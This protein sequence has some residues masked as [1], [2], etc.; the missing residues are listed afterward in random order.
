MLPESVRQG[1]FC[2]SFVTILPKW[3]Q[4]ILI[5][6]LSYPCMQVNMGNMVAASFSPLKKKARNLASHISTR[7][8]VSDD[9]PRTRGRRQE[10]SAK[11]T[12]SKSWLSL[13]Q[14]LHTFASF[15]GN[16]TLELYSKQRVHTCMK[17]WTVAHKGTN[18][19]PNFLHKACLVTEFTSFSYSHA[20]WYL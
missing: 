18:F 17:F 4:N 8:S 14:V 5:I 20:L 6:N 19:R 9:S 3:S 15:F 12:P 16:K 1:E 13:C 2:F 10:G 11:N 7:M